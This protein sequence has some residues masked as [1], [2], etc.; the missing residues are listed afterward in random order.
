MLVKNVAREQFTVTNAVKKLTSTYIH[1]ANEVYRVHY[2]D[3]QV[4]T[5]A[6]RVTFDGTDPE[7][8]T[9]GKLWYPTKTY[10]VWGEV[11]MD[12]IEFI[13]E[14]ADATLVVDYFGGAF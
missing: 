9:T 14:T 1:D 5:D 3:I 6:V 10:R 12:L 11:N 2:A 13:R 8:A 7:A 4:I